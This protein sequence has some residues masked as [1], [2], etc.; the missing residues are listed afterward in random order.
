MTDK[1]NVLI[2]E[3]SEKKITVKGFQNDKYDTDIIHREGKLIL[4]QIIRKYILDNR[5]TEIGILTAKVFVYEEMIK[6]SNFAPMLQKQE[7]I[8]QNTNIE[9][10]EKEIA[11]HWYLVGISDAI[12]TKL[13]ICDEQT[14]KDFESNFK[15]EHEPYI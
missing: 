2:K 1:I 6:K 15:I 4:E 8:K 14:I 11:K 5:D 10:N 3:L 12:D 13:E 9:L 7:E